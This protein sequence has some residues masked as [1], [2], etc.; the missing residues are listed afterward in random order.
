MFAP[1]IT[2][3]VGGWA[4]REERYAD[5]ANTAS[6]LLYSSMQDAELPDMVDVSDWQ[7]IE[8]QGNQG[9]CQ[10]H[11][12]SSVVEVSRV[13]SGAPHLQLSRA[14]AYYETQ[15]LD[16]IS[17]D[18]GSTIEGGI[19]LAR[20]TGLVSEAD[21][22]YPSRYDNRR[23]PGYESMVKYKVG[24]HSSITIWEEAIKHIGLIGGISI[25]ISWGDE[26]DS[27]VSR[28]GILDSFTGRG[29]DGHAVALLGYRDTHFDGSTLKSR[30]IELYNSWSQR[31]G[32]RGRCLVSKRAFDAMLNHKWTV[33][34]G[35]HGAPEPAIPRPQYV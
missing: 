19:R 1:M 20:E 4:Q 13:R 10:G 25:G 35:L 22:P 32:F 12:L 28:T 31:W 21:W 23:P 24:G 11:A 9:A 8:D 6:P 5:I 17:G 33:M 27:Q 26:I 15:R 2:T 34:V 29:G 18:R 16:K 3:K 30:H 7:P 14:G